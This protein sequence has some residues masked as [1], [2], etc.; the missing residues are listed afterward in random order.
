MRTWRVWLTALF[1]GSPPLPGSHLKGQ[2]DREPRPMVGCHHLERGVD[3]LWLRD[4]VVANEAADTR[5]GPR[6]GPRRNRS[7]RRTNR[8]SGGGCS[9][10]FVQCDKGQSDGAASGGER[11]GVH[12]RRA[13]GDIELNSAP[14]GG[15]TETN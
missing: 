2:Q 14:C 1:S 6:S 7:S 3:R 15:A 10:L 4:Q 5:F 9:K 12:D 11:R 13:V 8:R